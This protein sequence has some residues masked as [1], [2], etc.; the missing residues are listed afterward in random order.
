MYFRGKAFEPTLPDGSRE[1]EHASREELFFCERVDL[2]AGPHSVRLNVQFSSAARDDLITVSARL[3]SDAG[4]TELASTS[5]K[6]GERN[7]L[8]K[9]DLLTL[10]FTLDSPR[11]VIFEG[12]VSA[13]AASTHLRHF[14]AVPR[15]DLKPDDPSFWF[16]P[17]GVMPRRAL[18]FVV[19]GTTA[20]CNANC[21]HCPTNKAY[22][23]AQARGVMSLELFE[24][25][26]RN[27]GQMNFD[28][29]FCFG[30]HG[31]PLQDPLLA[32]RVELIRQHCPSAKIGIST[33]AATYD[34]KRHLS[35]LRGFDDVSVHVEALNPDIYD[36]VMRPLKTHRTFPRVD[37]LIAELGDLVRIVTPVHSGNIDDVANLKLHWEAKGAGETELMPLSNRCGQSPKFDQMALAP[38]GVGCDPDMVNELAIDWDGAVLTCCQD[39]HRRSIIGDLKTETVEQVMEN[40]ARNRVRDL[41]NQKRWGEL[42][43]CVNCRWDDGEKLGCKIQARFA[44]HEQKR[45]FESNLFKGRGSVEADDGALVVRA[46]NILGAFGLRKNAPRALLSGPK[47]RFRAGAYQAVFDVADSRIDWRGSVT[48]D[49]AHGETVIARQRVK[50]GHTTCMVNFEVERDTDLIYFR[51]HACAASLRFSGVTVERVA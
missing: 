45:R 39:F 41:F 10:A 50:P 2:L 46:R 32:R 11:T 7:A 14:S 33:N 44:P 12:R 31:E 49:V 24:R 22:T 43:T 15:P 21:T 18:K 4:S 40:A 38:M 28:G 26:V 42:E 9:A 48:M 8:Q 30:L 3:E 51:L 16:Y 17:D 20:T 35:V 34:P 37:S 1:N 27:L 47:R 23:L 6:S 25:I 13:N 29:G 36:D 19:L 5:V